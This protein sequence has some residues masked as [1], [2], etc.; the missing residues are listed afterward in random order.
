MAIV[1]LSTARSVL[2]IRRGGAATRKL[3]AQERHLQQLPTYLRGGR[4]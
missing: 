2:T 1:T 4:I 3:S